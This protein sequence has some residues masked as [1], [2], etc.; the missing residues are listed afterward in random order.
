MGKISY[1]YSVNLSVLFESANC[2]FRSIYCVCNIIYFDNEEN[3]LF[4]SFIPF[5][6]TF[7]SNNQRQP[8][9]LGWG[10]NWT[11]INEAKSNL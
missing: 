5:Q 7:W 11:L 6:L 4:M 2:N 1:K 10:K 9:I 8:V 3:F